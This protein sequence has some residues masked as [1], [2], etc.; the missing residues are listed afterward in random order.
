MNPNIGYS[1]RDK[2]KNIWF[3]FTLI[4]EKVE[5]LSQVA[6]VVSSLKISAVALGLWS[7]RGEGG[8]GKRP[9]VKGAN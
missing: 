3:C 4:E 7:I 6:L 1:L 8:G 9:K 5:W 2:S